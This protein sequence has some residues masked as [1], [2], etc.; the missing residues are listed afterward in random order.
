MDIPSPYAEAF[1]S[2]EDYKDSFDTYDDLPASL[3]WMQSIGAAIGKKFGVTVIPGKDRWQID[4]AKKEI[5][6]GDIEQIYSRRGVL[7]LILNGVGRVAYSVF[8]PQTKQQAVKFAKDNGVDPKYGKHY[9]SLVKLVDEIRTD[10][11]MA[12]EYAGGERVVDTMHRQA[13]E[14]ATEALRLMAID[15]R[16]RREMTRDV[17][18][19]YKALMVFCEK[20]AKAPADKTN[21]KLKDERAKMDNKLIAM[22]HDVIIK[23]G[24]IGQRTTHNPVT[25]G[26]ANAIVLMALYPNEVNTVMKTMVRRY[27]RNDHIFRGLERIE[28]T[29]PEEEKEIIKMAARIHED[30]EEM[31]LFAGHKGGHAQYVLAKAEQYYHAQKLKMEYISPY[32]GVDIEAKMLDVEMANEAALSVAEGLI[33]KGFT[34]DVAESLE[35]AKELLPIVEP[36]PYL[37][38]TDKKQEDKGNMTQRVA[39]AKAGG[40]RPQKRKK[41]KEKKSDGDRT[42]DRKK[43]ESVSEDRKKQIDQ[44][45]NGYSILDVSN[46][47]PLEK[48]AYILGPYMNRI[49]ST[50]AKLRRIL[51]VNDPSGM[52]GAYRR[53]KAL[54]PKVLYKHRLDDFKLFSRREK[55]KDLSYGFALMADLS[56]STQSSYNTKNKRLIQDE[57]LASALLIAEVAER[58][59][60]RVMASVGFFTDRAETVKRPG[61]YL[62]RSTILK[63]V[64][65]GGGTNV[66]DAGTKIAE[67]LNE[68]HEFK[69]MNKTVIFITDGAFSTSEFMTTVQAA[70][71]YGASIAYFQIG[72]DTTMPAQVE[73]FVAQ[74]ARG[75]RVRSRYVDPGQIH[76]LPESIAQLM[77]ETIVAK[78]R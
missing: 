68:M 16:A 24:V 33:K 21:D 70:K 71:K 51:K 34:K 50:A 67:D 4:N 28:P 40:G 9:G 7:G 15:M 48:Y 47:S 54:N 20:V 37:D 44:Q 57:M 8:F 58:I 60:E 42:K 52:R 66:E 31:K 55:E 27:V 13:Y 2:L 41:E 43:M 72:D 62:N 45:R 39:G 32:A 77:K 5:L 29:S 25:N 35:F 3:S 75:V 63:N 74:N 65:H 46:V 18:D 22:V 1:A 38:L 76:T 53:G 61:F 6:C 26:R 69:V 36:F 49:A 56:G 73:K 14:G 30:V 78:E 12:H 11:L 64:S 23:T 19:F 17:L 10:D 59:G